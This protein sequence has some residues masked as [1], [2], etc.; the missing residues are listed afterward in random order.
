[1]HF[2]C[3]NA[4][5]DKQLTLCFK[6]LAKECKKNVSPQYWKTVLKCFASVLFWRLE[7]RND[8]SNRFSACCIRR[9]NFGAMYDS[10]CKQWHITMLGCVSNTHW[11]HCRKEPCKRLVK[12]VQQPTI[13]GTTGLRW[14]YSKNN[15][16]T[17]FNKTGCHFLPTYK[18]I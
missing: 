14:A 5:C 12:L 13:K 1:M 8:V 3:P 15:I 9:R 17:N 4:I 6:A 11:R 7:L 2:K 10:K 18:P 16:C